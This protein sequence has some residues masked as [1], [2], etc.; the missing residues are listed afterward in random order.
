[1]TC[2]LP[3]NA[4]N[5]G[6]VIAYTTSGAEALAKKVP[7]AEVVAAFNTVPSEVL[8]GVFEAR[9]WRIGSSDLGSRMP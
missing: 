3:M 5:T 8:F 6:L 4:E 7:G 2:S 9:S 1:M